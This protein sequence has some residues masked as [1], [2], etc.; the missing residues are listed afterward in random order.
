MKRKETP[1]KKK[2][3]PYAY[4]HPEFCYM[5]GATATEVYVLPCALCSKCFERKWGALPGWMRYKCNGKNGHK[6]G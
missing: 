4:A 1:Q 2:S 6:K 5:C 3:W